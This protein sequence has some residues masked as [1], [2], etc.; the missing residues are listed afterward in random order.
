VTGGGKYGPT[1]G[2]LWFRLVFSLCGLVF[3]GFAI[4]VRGISGA[5]WFEIMG[6]G[7]VFL[8]GTAVWSAWK[9]FGRDRT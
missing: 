7:G 4:K 2:E 5:A 8:G 1:R 6:I 3:L 9:L